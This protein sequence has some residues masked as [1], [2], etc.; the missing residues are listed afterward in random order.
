MNKRQP[1]ESFKPLL[2]SLK[3]SEID[4][5]EDRD[6]IIVS[7]INDGTLDHWRWIIKTYGKETVREVLEHHLVS[8]FHSESLNLARTIFSLHPLRHAR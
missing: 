7:A 4:I 2:W 8:E 3:W 6:D 5:N 1:P